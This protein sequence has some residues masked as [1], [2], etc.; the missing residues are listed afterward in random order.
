MTILILNWRD[1]KN[2]KAGGAEI[3]TLEHA[4]VWI[5][6]GHTV[7]WFSQSFK[8]AKLQ[9]NIEGVTIFRKGN[10]LVY[11][12]AFLFYIKNKN[13]INAVVDEFHGLPYFSPL[14]VKKPILAFIHEVAGVIWD[15]MY[16]FPLNII[17]KILEP[18]FFIPYKTMPFITGA[19]SAAEDLEK[20]GIPKKNITVIHH[21]VITIPVSENV[22]R[23]NNPTYIFVNRLVKMKGVEDVLSAFKEII[24]KQHEA[25]LWIVGSGEEKYVASLKKMV[26][27]NNLE[28]SVKFWGFVSQKQKFE[29]YK[30]AHIL[31]HASV[32]E[33]W[34]LNVIEAASV[35]TPAIVYNVAGLKDAVKN[36]QTGIV[37][38]LNNPTEMAY[39]ATELLK[40]TEKYNQLSKNAKDWAKQFT[41]KRAGETS[42]M[43]IEKL[44]KK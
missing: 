2:P 14:Y 12:W 21:G 4:K 41:W 29:L 5:A 3:A 13:K 27:K 42:L 25:K 24:V 26:S 30:K 31:L 10:F 34:G 15:Y 32:K 39:Q 36:N 38:S 7:W 17:G 37:L 16:P 33:G 40:N 35:G 44:A 23:E 28:N 8:N 6:H 20:I 19:N 11:F 9:E 18:L 43:L 22:K 1:P